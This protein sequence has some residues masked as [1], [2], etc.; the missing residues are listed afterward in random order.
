MK[1][2]ILPMLLLAALVIGL[3][4]LGIVSVSADDDF[5]VYPVEGGNLYFDK[6]AYNMGTG[7]LISCEE[8]VTEAAIPAQINGVAVTT[9][10]EYA[11]WGCDK[12]TS[13]TIPDSVTSIGA[14]AFKECTSLTDMNL[15]DSV[16]SIGSTVFGDTAIYN[17]ADR[18]IDGV[19]YLDN[20]VIEAEQTVSGDYALRLGTVGIADSAFS[21]CSALTSVTIPGSVRRISEYAFYNCST[22]ARVTIGSGVT[23]VGES[24]FSGCSSLTSVTVPESVTSIGHSAFYGCSSLVSVALPDSVTYIGDAAF[25]GCCSLADIHIPDSVT[26][27]GG[28]AF[29]GTAIY[30][31]DDQ[32]IDDVLYLDNWLIDATEVT[33]VYSIR[34]GTVGIAAVAFA[35]CTDLTC[36]IIPDGVRNICGGVFNGCT[37]LTGVVIPDSVTDIGYSAFFDCDAL[38]G[39][40][41]M[42]DAPVLG[43]SVFQITDEETWEDINIPGLTLYYIEGKAGWTSPTWNGYPTAVWTPDD[44]PA[45][46]VIFT[47][48]AEKAWYHDAVEYAV[49]NGLM[50]GV[51]GGKFDPEG[52]MTR[53]MLV[54]VLWRYEGEPAEGENTFTDVPDGTWYTGAVAWAA[55]NGIVGGVGNGKFD[56]EGRI[57]REQMATL[58]FRYAQKKGI[59]TSKRGELSG[60][61]DSDKVSSWAKEAMRWAVA[62]GIINGSDGKLLPQGNATRAQVATLLMRFI[63]QIE[64]DA[65]PTEPTEPTESPTEPTEFPTEPTEF[66]T[67]PTESPTDPPVDPPVDPK[68]IVTAGTRKLYIGMSFEDLLEYAGEAEEIL[69][70]TSGYTWYVYGTK[71]YTDYAMAGVYENKV[72]AICASGAD[73]S[74][75]GCSANG[76]EAAAEA[77]D[78]YSINV[79]KDKNDNSAVYGILLTDKKFRVQYAET[80]EALAG[81]SRVAFHMA[82]AFR[83][84]HGVGILTWCDNAATA[85][86]L[87]SEDMAAQNYVSHTSA[88]GRLFYMR[89]RE[90]GV[91]YSTCAENLCAGYYSGIGANNAWVN[92]SGH[93]ANLL[94]ANMDRCGIGFGY[95]ADSDYRYY[96]VADYYQAR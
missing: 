41:F 31:L 68:H 42:G 36:V 15:P 4:P 24:A 18:W 67:E 9:I 52:T 55:A 13:V 96:A 94:N 73:F 88:D 90:N 34:M 38:Q 23:S 75:R 7:F 37:G 57:T 72:V 27:I 64:A 70:T 84:L 95:G 87:H 29:W 14:C 62:E 60:F 53:A 44:K 8:S 93:R 19:L 2:R 17:A 81:E 35:H 47:D 76:S 21:Q 30:N 3:L 6:S 51:G 43:N 40:Y 59:D 92:S 56:P 46:P 28:W 86:R 61:P 33:G 85:A 10:G 66:P 58:L 77:D 48:V 5:I 74:Y 32:W 45:E 71:D 83:V 39:V 79:L 91:L 22:L 12:L 89:L 82:N 16:V 26:Y 65:D 54:T 69:P 80:K 20:W 50:K 78:T 11:F 1:R 63:N 49:T 25:Q